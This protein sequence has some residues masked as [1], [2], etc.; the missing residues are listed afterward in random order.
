MCLRS[1][2]GIRQGRKSTIR[3][4]IKL[5]SD[6]FD[7]TLIGRDTDRQDSF[8]GMVVLILNSSGFNMH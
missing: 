3:L 6:S 1:N 7:Y 5:I 4:L 8:K 2:S